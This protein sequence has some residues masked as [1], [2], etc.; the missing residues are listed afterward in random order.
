MAD[1]KCTCIKH[2]PQPDGTR[3][4]TPCT[5]AATHRLKDPDGV[6]FLC[7]YHARALRD[8]YE[9]GQLRKKRSTDPLKGAP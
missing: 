6:A 4:D 8:M 5:S 7:R 3:I 2:E 9:P 1:H